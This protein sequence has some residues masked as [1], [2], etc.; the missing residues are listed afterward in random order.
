MKATYLQIDLQNLF[1]AARNLGQRIDF[2]KTW[3]YFNDRETEF[4]TEA[5]IYM[6]RSTDFDSHKF[7]IK[8][9][10]IGYNLKIK[11]STK[12]IRG[13][14]AVYRYSNQDVAI[15][16]DCMDK[17]QSFDKW[18][19]MSG[20]GD[21]ADLAAYLK[22]HGKQV[23]IWSFKRSYNPWL[24]PYADRLY[25]IENNFFYKKPKINVFGFNRGIDGDDL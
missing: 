5:T 12:T 25:F 20:D 21:F 2:E 4:L 3:Q 15:T 11:N 16:V 17:L 7:E 10:S 6:I 9:K 24:E 8:L 22:K 13:K 19:L 14:K 23:E 18:I 1:Y